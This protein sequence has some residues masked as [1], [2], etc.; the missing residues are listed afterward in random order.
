MLKKSV[1]AMALVLG[2][3]S[4]AQA[5]SSVVPQGNGTVT[6]KGSIVDAPC[7]IDP[8]SLDQTVQL[9]QVSN[10]ALADGGTSIPQN[11]DIRLTG[12][13]LGTAKTVKTTFTGAADPN[14]SGGKA[15]GITGTAKGAGI[16]LTDAAGA[17]ITLGTATTAQTIQN[18][19]NTLQFSAYLQGDTT[20]PAITP[21]DFQGVTDF[22]IAY[23]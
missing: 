12:C 2:S 17:Q 20:G 22:T 7:S 3:V 14:S 8:D 19:N 16:I 13:A 23:Q 15:L 5:A 1:I 21:G 18:G 10:V 4:L 6:F 11:F 9:G